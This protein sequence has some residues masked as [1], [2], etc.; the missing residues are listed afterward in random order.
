MFPH[1]TCLSAHEWDPQN[2]RVPKSSRSM[3]EEISRNIVAVMTKGGFPDLTKTDSEIA[4]VYQ[5]YDIGAITSR[6]IGS[7]KVTLIQSMIVSE[8]KSTLQDD[9]QA[10]KIS[11]KGTSFKR[12]T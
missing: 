5:I 1:V 8:A 11:V 6:I 9:P 2:F 10:N 4:S 7:V 12:V 3:E